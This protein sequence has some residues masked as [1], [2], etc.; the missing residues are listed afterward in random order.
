MAVKNLKTSCAFPLFAVD[1]KIEKTEVREASGIQ[2]I[3]LSLIKNGQ[4]GRQSTAVKLCDILKDFGVPKDLLSMFSKEMGYLISEKILTAQSSD[5]WWIEEQATVGEFMFT[6]LGEKLFKDKAIPTN[7]KTQIQKRVY[8]DPLSG[9]FTFGNE[10]SIIKSGMENSALKEIQLPENDF[11]FDSIKVWAEE[12]KTH[13]EIKPQEQIVGVS[14]ENKE[15]V[16]HKVEDC[17]TIDITDGNL[18]LVFDEKYEQFVKRYFTGALVSS[19][20]ASKSKFGFSSNIKVHSIKGTKNNPSGTNV[21][22]P[23]SIQTVCG[24]NADLVVG[25]GTYDVAKIRAKAVYNATDKR[26]GTAEFIAFENREGSAYTAAV[27]EFMDKTYGFKVQIPL[28][29]EETL[30][31]VQ[32]EGILSALYDE[33]AQEEFNAKAIKVIK[34]I[35]DVKKDSNLLEKYIHNAILSPKDFEDRIANFKTANEALS[36][37]TSIKSLAESIFEDVKRDITLDNVGFYRQNLLPIKNAIGMSGGDFLSAMISNIKGATPEKMF[38]ALMTAGFSEDE[39]LPYANVVSEYAGKVLTGKEIKEVND[40]ANIFSVIGNKLKELKKLLGVK[41][42]TNYKINAEYSAAEVEGSFRVFK[43]K[44][45]RIKRHANYASESF[46]ELKK[47]IDIFQ[48]IADFIIMEK[49]A[50]KAPQKITKQQLEQKLNNGRLNDCIITT[51]VVLEKVLQGKKFAG[52]L[53]DMIHGAADMKL[54]SDAEKNALHDLRLARNNYAHGLGK[55]ITYTP[56]DI[57]QW[58]SLVFEIKER[59]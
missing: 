21:Y 25:Y 33:I 28:I 59:K 39:I 50:T 16:P 20:I 17:L 54:I 12:N 30:T 58:I 3:L 45:D 9:R 48:D 18:L 47:Y 24:T 6:A 49:E 26:I 23:A 41:S 40:L 7:K 34:A 35:A 57:R 11:D 51:A 13:L 53:V 22:L 46:A 14:I 55:D 32:T 2:Y 38:T 1:I 15:I 10:F 37:N 27:V 4:D 36:G 43:D 31:T 5:K 8:F 19:I 44:Y 29:I 56:T 52:D 42:A